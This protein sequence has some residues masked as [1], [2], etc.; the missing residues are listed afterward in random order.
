MKRGYLSLGA[1]KFYTVKGTKKSFD[2]V[3]M[4]IIVMGNKMKFGSW[5]V[6]VAYSG[7]ATYVRYIFTHT[8]TNLPLGVL[9]IHVSFTSILKLIQ[10]SPK[11]YVYLIWRSKALWGAH[12]FQ[13]TA[14]IL[15]QGALIASTRPLIGNNDNFYHR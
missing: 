14:G 12:S 3:W 10:M 7:H 6:A 5:N 9:Y 11:F 13:S 8:H 2:K 15:H 1:Q 4:T